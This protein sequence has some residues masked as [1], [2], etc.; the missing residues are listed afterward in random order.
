MDCTTNDHLCFLLLVFLMDH[1]CLFFLSCVSHAFTSVHCC[2][3][4][5]CW[6]RADRF[7]LVDDVYC[8]LCYFPMWYPGSGVILDCIVS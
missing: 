3:V 5:T 8:I 1:L 6:E 4:G 2:L 7:A